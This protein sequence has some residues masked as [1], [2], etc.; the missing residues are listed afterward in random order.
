MFWVHSVAIKRSCLKF[1][2][3]VSCMAIL[4]SVGNGF[5]RYFINAENDVGIPSID[6]AASIKSTTRALKTTSM[7]SDSYWLKS[8]IFALFWLLN[9]SPVALKPYGNTIIDTR[10]CQRRLRPHLNS[11]SFNSLS[12]FLRR[13]FCS[14]QTF[15][16]VY[17][18]TVYGGIEKQFVHWSN[19]GKIRNNRRL[20]DTDLPVTNVCFVSA[21]VV[22]RL[23]HRRGVYWS[24]LLCDIAFE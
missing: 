12:S 23:L 13:N 11:C 20:M 24:L 5:G 2:I 6:W 3:L 17:I 22:V 18:Y 10:T 9:A 16:Y 4:L 7:E 15:W 21:L 1:W 14:K 19:N 8:S